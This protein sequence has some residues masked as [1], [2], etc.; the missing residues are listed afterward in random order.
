[1]K[2]IIIV[3]IVAMSVITSSY[4]Q[5]QKGY[6]GISLGPSIPVGD[7]ASKNFDN[8]EAGYANTGAVFDISFAYKLGD[9]N[10]GI[11]ALIRGQ[12]NPTDAQI[13]ADEFSRQFP[14][15][16]WTVE[17]D[18]W[19][20][21][22][23]M[24][25]GFGSFPVSEKISFDPRAMIGFLNATAPAITVSGSGS[26]GSGWIKVESASASSFAYLIGAGFKFDIS[27]KLF[28]L[29]NLDY[30]NSNPEF[31]NV[32]TITSDGDRQ[33]DTFNQTIGSINLSV[34]IALK[35]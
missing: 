3:A 32:E 16:N 15:A 34:G 5:E 21:G 26:G 9:G 13:I 24:F 10:F 25:G 33:L 1:M 2:K 12:A 28:L 18:S 6:I 31:I 35:I 4:A 8:D 17:S 30:L 27:D 29:T 19:G 22:G 20:I 7:L 14:S 11:T 23:L